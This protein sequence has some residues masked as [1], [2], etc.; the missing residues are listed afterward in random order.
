VTIAE[1]MKAVIERASRPSSDQAWS[2]RLDSAPQ[3]KNSFATSKLF[4]IGGLGQTRFV[5]TNGLGR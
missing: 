5:L 2:Q 3:P 1:K 4:R